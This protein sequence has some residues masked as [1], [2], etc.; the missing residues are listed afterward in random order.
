[1]DSIP[2]SKDTIWKTGLKK[3]IQQSVV[4]KRTIL[5]AEINSGL[6]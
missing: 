6:G 5:L 2:P 1:M 4:Y 3:K